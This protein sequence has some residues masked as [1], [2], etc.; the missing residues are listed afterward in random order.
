MFQGTDSFFRKGVVA[1]V[2]WPLNVWA[3]QG[4]N[5]EKTNIIVYLEHIKIWHTALHYY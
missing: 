3:L 4:I 2:T 1:R 5:S